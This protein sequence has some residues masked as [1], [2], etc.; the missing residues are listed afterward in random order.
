MGAVVLAD[1][2][3]QLKRIFLALQALFRLHL[4]RFMVM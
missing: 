1:L 4:R 3:G 2:S